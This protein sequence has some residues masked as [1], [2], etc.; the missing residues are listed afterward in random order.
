MNTLTELAREIYRKIKLCKFR[1]KWRAANQNN[2]TV[3]DNVFPFELVKVGKATY[4]SLRVL[5]GNIGSEV[6]IGS[7]CS[8]GP[9]VTFIINDDHPLDRISTFPFRA[10]LLG[11][12]A[13]EGIDRGPILIG[14][15]VWLGANATVLSGVTIG[16]G[17]VVAA[18]AVVTRDLPP[19]AICGGVPA[20]VLR[21]RLPKELI[22][23]TLKFNWEG[24]DEQFVRAHLSPLYS[25]LSAD[26][27]AEM[28]EGA[29][30]S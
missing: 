12:R 13:Y 16:Q 9:N 3:P 29:H 19:Y 7:Y 21:Y 4:G 15:D 6:R 25:T 17:A 11:E 20:K 28:A 30:V 22:Q 18:G 8:I 14:D 26:S 2:A 23:K 24:I 27:F 5:Y 10:M 1:A